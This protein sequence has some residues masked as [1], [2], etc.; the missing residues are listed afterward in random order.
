MVE[1]ER[2]D[3]IAATALNIE[4]LQQ[5]LDTTFFGNEGRLQYVSIIGS[6]NTAAMKLAQEGTAGEGFVVLT[7][8][9]TAGRGR[10]GRPWVDTFGY[11]VLAST[12]LKPRFP[13]SLLVMIASLA[14]VD[15]IDEVCKVTAA[16][17]WPNDVLLEER[18]VSGILIETTHNRSGEVIAILGI[19]VNV[20]RPPTQTEFEQNLA[21]KAITLEAACGHRVSREIFIARLL[22]HIESSYISLQQ[23]TIHSVTTSS[24]IHASNGWR[25]ASRLIRERWRSRLS[26]LGR[27]I[28]VRQGDTVLSGIAEDVDDSGELFL[29]CHSGERVSIT[30]GD[31]G[32]P[33]E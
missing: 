6:T 21:K 27:T 7:D 14:V 1:R 29:R 16:I 31:I 4:L 25:P 32:Y 30:W 9:Q 8:S 2:V 24:S 28:E 3:V 19:G 17:K 12:V 15:A 26:T 10:L 33:T 22:K 18:K 5:L 23:E 13:L 11:N 20:Y